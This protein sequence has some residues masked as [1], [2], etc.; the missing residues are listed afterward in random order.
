[1]KLALK[2]HRTKYIKR[3]LC[4]TLCLM[5]MLVTFISDMQECK[6]MAPAVAIG[7]WAIAGAA[8]IIG[9]VLVAQGLTFTD[10]NSLSKVVDWFVSGSDS[11]L[12]DHLYD[13]CL[14]FAING[15]LSIPD[16]VWT[17]S[18]D[19]VQS[20]FTVGN[21]TITKHFYIDALKTS[22][23]GTEYIDYLPVNYNVPYEEL[24]VG[25]PSKFTIGIDTYE[26]VLVDY[27]GKNKDLKLYKNGTK[28]GMTITVNTRVPWS[29]YLEVY[30]SY[31]VN[32]YRIRVRNAGYEELAWDDTDAYWHNLGNETTS[33]YSIPAEAGS[34][35]VTGQD[36]VLNPEWDIKVNET[37]EIGYPVDLSALI[38][39]TYE[40]V[41]NPEYDWEEGETPSD[42]PMAPAIDPSWLQGL[43]DGLF[44]RIQ[45]V[46]DSVWNWLQN[47]WNSFLQKL[48]QGLQPLTDVLS[49]IYTSVQAIGVSIS[50]IAENI[51]E[52][53]MNS[54]FQNYKLPDLFLLLLLLIIAVI[55]LLLRG[56]VYIISLY[57][58]SPSSSMFNEYVVQGINFLKN[59]QI[60]WF[61]MSFFSIYE[62]LIGFLFGLVV[63][64]LS[65]KFV[66]SLNDGGLLRYLRNRMQEGD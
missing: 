53:D 52:P 21:Q 29:V 35:T 48:Q 62:V 36:V 18:R 8:A 46:L 41:L 16:E 1:M 2:I 40:D 39:A 31:G 9:A 27:I 56:L 63:I 14:N 19:F 23:G 38:G 13:M 43:L 30:K 49:N 20:N 34:I 45:D 57:S 50:A 32:R 17:G 26:Y 4:I 28:T 65:K 5:I 51:I 58:L 61:N 11:T 22:V 33:D 7:G 3:I 6:A 60:P 37:R 59:Q 24:P 55:R 44:G 25:L 64:R 42:D 10:E 54:S 66:L 12:R 15:V 47:F